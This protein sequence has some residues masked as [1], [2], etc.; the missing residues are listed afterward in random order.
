M[1]M[2]VMM[3]VYFYSYF[4]L[5]GRNLLLYGFGSKKLLIESF[6]HDGLVQNFPCLVVNGYHKV[7]NC[8]KTCTPLPFSLLN[9]IYNSRGSH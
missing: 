1:M 9:I 2:A 6:L 5:L 3:T 7:K 4:S 8:R